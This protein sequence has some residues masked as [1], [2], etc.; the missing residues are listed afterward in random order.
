VENHLHG[1]VLLV[2]E[3]GMVRAVV[4]KYAKT[5][6][7]EVVL[8]S[9]LHGK[10]GGEQAWGGGQGQEETNSESGEHRLQ[11]N[12]SFAST[13]HDMH[14]VWVPD[15]GWKKRALFGPLSGIRKSRAVISVWAVLLPGSPFGAVQEQAVPERTGQTFIP[16]NGLMVLFPSNGMADD[17]WATKRQ[18]KLRASHEKE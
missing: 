8:V 4:E 18:G 15:Q 11:S 6:C 12:C 3:N 16:I 5:L 7:V 17:E 10:I 2:Y 14:T 13:L 9:H 1:S